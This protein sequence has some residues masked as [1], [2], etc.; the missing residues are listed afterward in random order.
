MKVLIVQI[1]DPDVSKASDAFEI[2]VDAL[3]GKD[4]MS[5]TFEC[6]STREAAERL[7]ELAKKEPVTTTTKPTHVYDE[8]GFGGCM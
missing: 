3:G 5:M 6:D 1:V 4:I 2:V 8:T 7:A